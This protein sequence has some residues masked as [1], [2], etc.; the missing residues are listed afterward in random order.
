MDW[1]NENAS[2]GGFAV[3]VG[4]PASLDASGFLRLLDISQRKIME[5]VI[6][7]IVR[8]HPELVG[9]LAD[10]DF[11]SFSSRARQTYYPIPAPCRQQPR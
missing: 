6:L 8:V 5:G 2:G 11:P 7:P 1:E 9:S 10:G 4:G 3:S